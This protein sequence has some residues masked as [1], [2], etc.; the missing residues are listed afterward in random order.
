M[1]EAQ[2]HYLF[3]IQKSIFVKSLSV[4]ASKGVFLQL[5]LSGKFVS[6]FQFRFAYTL[7]SE[8]VFHKVFKVCNMFP[9]ESTTCLGTAP[10]S[11]IFINFIY[12]EINVV[13]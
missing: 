9:I 4:G 2:L 1:N 6:K 11:E 12:A 7:G 13:L 8:N 10:C 5:K 3:C